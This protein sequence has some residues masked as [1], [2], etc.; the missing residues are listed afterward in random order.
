MSGDHL[1]EI[2][3]VSGFDYTTV[4]TSPVPQIQFNA[5]LNNVGFRQFVLAFDEA[6]TDAVDHA[7]D[8]KTPSVGLPADVFFAIEDAE[9]VISV[10]DFN[11]NKRLP[12]GLKTTDGA[13]FKIAVSNILNFTAADNVYIYDKET[14]IYHDIKNGVFEITLPAGTNIS[15]FEITFTNETLGAPQLVDQNL[16]ILQNNPG[17]L[18]TIYNPKNTNINS[19]SLIDM[20]GKQIL[21]K[22]NVGTSTSA[23]FSTSGLAEGIYIAKVISNGKAVAKK[24]SIVRT[25]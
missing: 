6:A 20:A 18:L 10:I 25:K 9:Y 11:I 15:R 16:S 2:A 5:I 17:Q 21:N 13:N 24:I 19:V 3:S 12:L 23:E 7:M 1:P 4:S 22:E 8:A 14:Q